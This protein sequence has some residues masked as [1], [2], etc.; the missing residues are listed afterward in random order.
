MRVYRRIVSRS[1]ATGACVPPV[2]PVLSVGKNRHS[3]LHTSTDLWQSSRTTAGAA[4]RVSGSFL[5]SDGLQFSMSQSDN[6]VSFRSDG[7]I[8][9]HHHDGQLSLLIQLIQQIDDFTTGR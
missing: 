7:F 9:S 5:T 6:A 1:C 8:V 2:T 3:Q 4:H